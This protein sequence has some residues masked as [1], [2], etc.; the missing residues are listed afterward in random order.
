MIIKIKTT[1]LVKFIPN[2]K[3]NFIFTSGKVPELMAVL[4]L[5]FLKLKKY[6]WQS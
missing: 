4:L 2:K 5:I 1:Q 3:I 6:F